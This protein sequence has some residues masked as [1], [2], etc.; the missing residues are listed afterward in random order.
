MTAAAENNIINLETQFCIVCNAKAIENPGREFYHFLPLPKKTVND[1]P[2]SPAATN[3]PKYICSLHFQ[4]KGSTPGGMQCFVCGALKRDFP[5]REF[6]PLHAKS[7]NLIMSGVPITITKLSAASSFICSLHF[8]TEDPI[9]IDCD[10]DGSKKFS[11]V[12]C[13]PTC[14]IQNPPDSRFKFFQVAS[15]KWWKALKVAQIPYMTRSVICRRH[16]E[17][18]FLTDDDRLTKDA[19][20]SLYLE[21]STEKY[22]SIMTEEP[23]IKGEP[24][25]IN[26]D[27]DSDPENVVEFKSEQEPEVDMETSLDEEVDVD[28]EWQNIESVE[29]PLLDTAEKVVKY[30]SPLFDLALAN[31]QYEAVNLLSRLEAIFKREMK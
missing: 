22:G 29:T 31:E 25:V 4:P 11:D 1:D 6:T 12:C 8:K 13:I 9:E 28:G 17:E 5:D 30:M 24:E 27:S 7:K 14:N 3:E 18:Q 10:D 21:S 20:P 2:V 16:F 26:L 23:D 15:V 19:V